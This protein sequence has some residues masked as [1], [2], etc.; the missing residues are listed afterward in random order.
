MDISTYQL[1]CLVDLQSAYASLPGHVRL[2]YSGE[3]YL[4]KQQ[5]QDTS[6]SQKFLPHAEPES[7][8][9]LVLTLP[10]GAT[11]NTFHWIWVTTYL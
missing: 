10:C 9:F 4:T 2:K 1:L 7:Q 8:W 3:N 11:Q 5:F 6:E